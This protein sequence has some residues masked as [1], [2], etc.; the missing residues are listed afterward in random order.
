MKLQVD[1][2]GEASFL[3]SILNVLQLTASGGIF[4]SVD[5]FIR[6]Y[7]RYYSSIRIAH[8][9]TIK[10]PTG[11]Q[12]VQRA[13]PSKS[14]TNQSKVL[15]KNASKELLAAKEAEAAQILAQKDD[16]GNSTRFDQLIVFL[17]LIYFD[18][19]YLYV[20]YWQCC[21]IF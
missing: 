4:P 8:T 1:S 2:D 14:N 20:V 13:I 9:P 15:L 5:N 19:I 21:C 7:E 11:S 18:I 10:L 12:R 17:I 6:D 16:F 3:K